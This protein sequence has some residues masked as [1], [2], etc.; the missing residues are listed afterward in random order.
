MSAARSAPPT[1]P[2]RIAA[3]VFLPFA[4]AY[5]LSYLYRSVNAV[6]APD[7]VPAFALTPSQL[8]LLTSAYFLSFAAFQLPLGLLLDR[9]GPRR[10]DA[11]LVL[12]AACG[13][14]VFAAAPDPGA[15]IAGRA[16]IGLGV[17]GC[18]MSGLKA[19][20]LWFPLARLPAMN[21]WMF[22]AG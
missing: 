10:T 6:I 20:V 4:A 7:L 13:A 22:F 9:Y 2:R 16:L 19:N 21:G 15:L 1:L 8:G 14:L 12:I 11:A 17:S 5:T 18:L 3:A